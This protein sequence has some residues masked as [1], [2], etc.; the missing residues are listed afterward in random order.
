[1]MMIFAVLTSKA[2]VTYLNPKPSELLFFVMPV[3]AVGARAVCG[4]GMCVVFW[5]AGRQ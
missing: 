1:M 3:R 2:K 4:S 5:G